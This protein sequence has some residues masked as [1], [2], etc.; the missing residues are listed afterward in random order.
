M[1]YDNVKKICEC[2]KT[3]PFYTGSRCV[4]CYLPQYW[5]YDTKACEWCDK[6]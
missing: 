4:A 2:P 6:N 3:A 1:F 5:N